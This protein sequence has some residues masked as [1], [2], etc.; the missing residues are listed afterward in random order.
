M[1]IVINVCYGGYSLSP[2]GIKEFA[3]LKGKEAYFFTDDPNTPWNKQKYIPI[4]PTKAKPGLF[5]IAFSI[6]NP[7][8][9]TENKKQQEELRKEYYLSCR[10][11]PRTDKDLVTVVEKLGKA[12]NGACAELKV[13]EIPDGIDYEIEEYDG[14][15]SVHER[16]L[17]WG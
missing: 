12:A 8:D 7:N 13:I 16:H 6:P 10:P 1:K 15:E 14:I 4:D 2:L 17:S 5:F 9:Y 3:A 11:E